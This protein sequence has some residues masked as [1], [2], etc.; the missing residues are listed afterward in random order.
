[1]L[2]NLKHPDYLEPR[3][4]MLTE[5]PLP[6]KKAVAYVRMSTEKQNYSIQHQQLVI[7]D[8]ALRN[9]LV[10]VRTYAD[11]GKSG[12]R[13]EG[14]AGLQKL[15]A[16]V[17]SGRADFSCIL[18]Y[19]VSRWGR[20]QDAD[21][22][23][24]YEFVC[25]RA[26]I[27]V[28]YCAELF[29][30]D[31]SPMAAILKSLKRL[32]AG[33]YSRELSS[34]V[35]AAQSN[36]VLMGFKQGGMA[37][38]GLR[39]VTVD[40]N[41]RR[42]IVLEAG[43]RKH[44][45][46]DRV[47]LTPGPDEEA[48]VVNKIY[49]WYLRLKLGDKRIA[50]ML[51]AAGIDGESGRPWTKKMVSSVLTNE[52]YV[53]HS[54][55]NRTSYK[56]KKRPVKNPPSMWIRKDDAFTALVPKNIFE[57]AQA[58]R[59]ER[60]RRR[61]NE[62]LLHILRDIHAKHGKI[63]ALL[64]AQHE[65]SPSSQTFK[66][67]FGTLANAYHQA[68]IASSEHFSYVESRRALRTIR[69]SLV[70]QVT[71]LIKEAGGTAMPA[72]GQDRL[73]VNDQLLVKIMAVRCQHEGAGYRWRLRTR[74]ATGAEFVIAAQMNTT[75][76]HIINYYLL[77][78]GC[79]IGDWLALPTRLDADHALHRHRYP[80]LESMFGLSVMKRSSAHPA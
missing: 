26:G 36:F 4:Y 10:I 13:M 47:V 7:D 53:G 46:T 29:A 19:D 68:G 31:G 14:R 2:I 9:E 43:E 3:T 59:A 8:Y 57:E 49:D 15:L 74:L 32:M 58:T 18:V 72:E 69:A 11:S 28:I 44:M 20:F 73:L 79:L 52:K 22:S 40:Q 60:H 1:M 45:P 62:E 55:F 16:D 54:V 48:M 27:E 30:G 5:A 70:A 64:I 50:D 78:I 71:E 66:Y 34:K 75:N 76:R 61:T 17:V 24:Y 65:A 39:R 12:L 35:F 6:E 67:H 37:G 38:Y 56:L 63:S 51:N 80:D 21:E 23:A 25:R 42:K 33:E 41:G 77:P